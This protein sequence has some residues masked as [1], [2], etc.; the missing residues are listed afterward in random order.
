MP[1]LSFSYY[2]HRYIYS[3]LDGY[4]A[5]LGIPIMHRV[6]AICAQ[7][8]S[9]KIMLSICQTIHSDASQYRVNN[10][11]MFTICHLEHQSLKGKGRFVN[12]WFVNI[13]P[14]VKFP[15]LP[16]SHAPPSSLNPSSARSL[17]PLFPSRRPCPVPS[18]PRSFPSSIL[19]PSPSLPPLTLSPCIASSLPPLLPPSLP[20][21]PPSI[22][23]SF[24]PSPYFVIL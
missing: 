21:L 9:H 19:P 20:H 12:G 16:C 17:P 6:H 2:S 3:T 23:P 14:P 22:H 18:L 24:P 11:Y 4:P 13:L 7:S 8:P 1:E 15:S 10:L 5:S